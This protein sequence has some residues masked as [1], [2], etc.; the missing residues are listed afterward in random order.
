MA[1]A[2][3]A[4]DASCCLRCAMF[5]AAASEMSFMIA[6]L[7]KPRRGVKTSIAIAA[8]FAVLERCFACTPDPWSAWNMHFAP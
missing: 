5:K 6:A 4:A 8:C 2:A 3:N 7:S 1:V